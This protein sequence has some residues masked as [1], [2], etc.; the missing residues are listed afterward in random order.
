MYEKY[1]FLQFWRFCMV[2]FAMKGIVKL[3]KI[4]YSIADRM[5]DMF[6]IDSLIWLIYSPHEFFNGFYLQ[7]YWKWSRRVR[8]SIFTVQQ[9]EDNQFSIPWLIFNY[10]CNLLNIIIVLCLYQGLCLK[11]CTLYKLIYQIKL[12]MVSNSALF[13]AFPRRHCWMGWSLC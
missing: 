3:R 7:S 6:F 11:Y 9:T 5:L 10:Q 8:W 4:T 1:R 2:D 13:L 12:K